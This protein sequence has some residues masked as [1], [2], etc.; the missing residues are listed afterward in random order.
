[1]SDAVFKEEDEESLDELNVG[2][3]GLVQHLWQLLESKK[4]KEKNYSTNNFN[5]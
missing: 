4:K 2:D 1:V 3:P 5:K